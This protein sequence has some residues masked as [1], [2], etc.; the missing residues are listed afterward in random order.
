MATSAHIVQ[1]LMDEFGKTSSAA[2]GQIE[3]W[4]GGITVD[5]LSQNDGRFS[6]L[7]KS[8]SITIAVDTREY[9]INSDYNTAHKNFYQVD[10]DGDFTRRLTVVSEAEILERKQQDKYAGIKMAYVEYQTDGDDGP[11]YYLVLGE[12]PD[13]A[14]YYKFQYY[15]KPTER[16]TDL[17][18]NPEIV[19]MG[20][21]GSAN[22]YNPHS[23][24]DMA[25]YMRMRSGFSERPG[26]HIKSMTVRPHRGIRTHN[27]NM[28]TIGKGG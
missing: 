3:A 7:K 28:Q 1:S 5:L 4:V 23:E 6:K 22:Q 26:K 19:K 8:Q 13:A 16:D 20:V 24:I 18:L 17:I 15:R 2:R 9:K 11:G 21:R 27:R 25:T 12:D 10:S 14:G